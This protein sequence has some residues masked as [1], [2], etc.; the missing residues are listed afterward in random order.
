MAPLQPTE[1]DDEELHQEAPNDDDDLDVPA[2][3]AENVDV[4]GPSS[5]S[6]IE[7]TRNK[8]PATVDEPPGDHDMNED[9]DD[10]EEPNL[11]YNFDP[12]PGQGYPLYAESTNIGDKLVVSNVTD[13]HWDG[14]LDFTTAPQCKDHIG[15][16]CTVL[17]KGIR[18]CRIRIVSVTDLGDIMLWIS[19]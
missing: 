5:S 10:T 1:E 16:T 17:A 12:A 4:V 7:D 18:S 14:Y 2:A 15:R 6:R 13:M 8:A 9:E 11:S 3:G 19:Y